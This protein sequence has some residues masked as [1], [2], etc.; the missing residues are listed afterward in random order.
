MCGIAG[1]VRFDPREAVDEARLKRMRDVLRHRGPD[2]E[3]LWLE[4]PVGL[5]HRRLAIVDV[6]GG[7]QPMANEDG[8][9]WITYNGEIYNH[10]ALRPGLE[11]RGH[12]YRTRSDTETILHLY[13][14]EGERCV[15]R[16][17]GMFAF[18]LWDRTAAAAAAGARP[19]GHQAAV[20]RG[21]RRASCCSAPRSR[22]SSRRA[23]ARRRSTSAAL[24]EFLATRFVAGEETFFQRHPQA[25]AR[26]HVSSWSRARAVRSAPLLAAAGRRPT[27]PGDARES[28]T[29]AAGAPRGGRPEP[30]DER[31]AARA[32]PLRRPRLERRSRRSWR[33]MVA[34][35]GSA[36]SRSGSPTTTRNELRVRAAG[37]RRRSA[38]STTRSSVSPERVLRGA[39][40]AGLARG[41]A[42]RVPVQRPALLRVAAGP[43]A[44]QGG[45]HGR[46]RRRAVPRLQLVPVT[47]WNERL[48][49]AVLGDRRRGACARRSAAS[50]RALPTALA[51]L[52]APDVSRARA[53]HPRACS[54]RTS[55]CSRE[56]LQP[57]LLRD[58]S[59]SRRATRTRTRCA[60]SRRRGRARS[61]A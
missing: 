3:G 44:R 20:L 34:R 55:R 18:A 39:A 36:P 58:Q 60:A 23:G 45:A 54:T 48:G 2:G 10:A 47:A 28:A 35:A 40:P 32:L 16:L 33:R 17:Q 29:R 14:E 50:P 53:G 26:A 4:G 42:D 13:E 15:E 24:P 59:R 12:R 31:R 27:A 38:P 8:T 57:A 56:A 52:R 51:P 61:S 7:Q 41:R 49:R 5:A 1:I 6:A 9:V 46:G 21:D 22:R 11:A 43:R 37:G 30:S 19:P 25:A